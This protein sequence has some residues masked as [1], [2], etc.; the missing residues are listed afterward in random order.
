[1][2]IQ[3]HKHCPKEEIEDINIPYQYEYR[4]TI[5]YCLE[6]VCI[7]QLFFRRDNNTLSLYQVSLN[8]FAIRTIDVTVLT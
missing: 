1:M 7:N 3:S 5:N 8:I 2:L 4:M 6:L